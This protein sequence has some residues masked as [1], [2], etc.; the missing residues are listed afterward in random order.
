MAFCFFAAV[1]HGF[2]FGLDGES[3]KRTS[4]PVHIFVVRRGMAGGSFGRHGGCMNEPS[5]A[6][7]SSLWLSSLNRLPSSSWHPI[8][9][10]RCKL[11]KSA[12]GTRFLACMGFD[13]GVS[14]EQYARFL[15]NGGSALPCSL[16]LSFSVSPSFSFNSRM[17]FAWL[18][19]GNWLDLDQLC[20]IFIVIC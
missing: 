7:L 1:A 5:G 10:D 4:F 17:A 6:I 16:H 3:L 12:N 11:W 14:R 8:H 2:V 9:A 15:H 19:H 13:F 18:A 20:L